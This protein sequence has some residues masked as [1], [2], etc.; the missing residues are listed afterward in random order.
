MSFRNLTS[1][2]PSFPKAKVPLYPMTMVPAAP[3]NPVRSEAQ[4]L[5][6]HSGVKAFMKMYFNFNISKGG[7]KSEDTEEF[8]RCQNKY[9]KS[10]S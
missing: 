4:G 5:L 2:S 6:A 9:S 8:F 10:L 3:V 7:F 1:E